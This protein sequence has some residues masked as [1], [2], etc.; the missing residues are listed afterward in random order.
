MF[1]QKK[2]WHRWF[3]SWLLWKWEENGLVEETGTELDV[4]TIL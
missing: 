1:G 3:L 2:T 4:S